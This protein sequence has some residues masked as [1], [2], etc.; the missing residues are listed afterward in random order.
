VQRFNR[1]CPLI[2]SSLKLLTYSIVYSFANVTPNVCVHSAALDTPL[3]ARVASVKSDERLR[4][5]YRHAD[6]LFSGG[7]EFALGSSAVGCF[8]NH[9]STAIIP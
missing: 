4:R 1:G 6:C 7:I 5:V 8:S 9:P 3:A 2:P